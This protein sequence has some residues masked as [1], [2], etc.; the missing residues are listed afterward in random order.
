MSCTL[1]Y[2][3]MCDK[4]LLKF[5]AF[6]TYIG[7]L[8]KFEFDNFQIVSACWMWEVN[9]YHFNFFI[10]KFSSLVLSKLTTFDAI[11]VQI[12]KSFAKTKAYN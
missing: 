8:K 10:I 6:E 4:G 1:H 5:W 12:Q 2:I 7:F 3:Y 11:I 9:Y